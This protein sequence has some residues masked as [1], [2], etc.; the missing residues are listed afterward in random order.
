[1]EESVINFLN[2]ADRVTNCSV[3]GKEL[4]DGLGVRR[5]VNEM[6]ASSE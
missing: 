5:V 1:M 3:A 4:V 6:K 2:N